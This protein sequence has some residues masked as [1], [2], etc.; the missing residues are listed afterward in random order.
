MNTNHNINDEFDKSLT[1][2]DLEMDFGEEGDKKDEISENSAAFVEMVA[3]TRSEYEKNHHD[4]NSATVKDAEDNRQKAH[5]PLPGDRATRRHS[6]FESRQLRDTYKA[7]LEMEKELK[8]SARERMKKIGQLLQFNDSLNLASM[9]D[10]SAM[11]SSPSLQLSCPVLSYMNDDEEDSIE[12]LKFSMRKSGTLGVLP[13]DGSAKLADWET[14]DEDNGFK[15][16]EYSMS[17]K[18]LP[19]SEP[20][21]KR[22]A[23]KRRPRSYQALSQKLSTDHPQKVLRSF[24]V[25]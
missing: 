24:G 21:L 6:S 3:K 1:L 10:L 16:R 4:N 5:A 20:S 19:S 8:A 13:E 18:E 2:H 15:H 12:M 7:H 11:N 9:S 23:K 14:L 25:I 22:S 17:M